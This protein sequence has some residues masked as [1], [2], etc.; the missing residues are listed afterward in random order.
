VDASAS[1]GVAGAAGT[2]VSLEAAGAPAAG[3]A[4]TAASDE[5]EPAAATEVLDAVATAGTVA[6]VASTAGLPT[7]AVETAPAVVPAVGVGTAVTVRPLCAPTGA[8]VCTAG[9][10]GGGGDVGAVVAVAPEGEAGIWLDG[11]GGVEAACLIGRAGVLVGAAA[12]AF[13]RVLLT[14]AGSGCGTSVAIAAFTRDG[15]TQAVS[16]GVSLGNTSD[17]MAEE[18]L[19]CPSLVDAVTL[20][21]AATASPQTT[22]APR[23]PPNEQLLLRLQCMGPMKDEVLQAAAPKPRP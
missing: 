17:L 4:T 12:H 19:A 10:G 3:A 9:N 6:V 14:H 1:M 21:A 18:A 11:G 7:G 13:T 23:S 22:P 15:A 20:T 5:V 8:R 2:A 16:A